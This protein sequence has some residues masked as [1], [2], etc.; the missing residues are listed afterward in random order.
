MKEDS[1]RVRGARQNNLK[2]IDIDIPLGKITVVTGVS[3]SGK[4][5]LAF[6]TVY[7]EGQRRYVETFSAYTRQFLDRMDRPRVDKIIGIPPAV[8]ID[9]ANP[10]RTSRSTVGTMTELADHLRI[11]FARGAELYCRSC[12]RRVRRDSPDSALGEIEAAGFRTI[13][14]TFAVPLSEKTSAESLTAILASQGFTRILRTDDD[15]LEVVQDRF[16]LSRETR[17]RLVED[18]ES[19]FR[20][21]KGRARVYHL[22]E[23]R[24]GVLSRMDFS[25]DFHCASCDIH[26]TEPHPGAFSFNSAVGAC[27]KCRG[28]GRVIDFDLDL[29]VPDGGKSLRDGAVK[30]WQ[31][32]SYREC[33]RDLEA[34]SRKRGVPLDIPWRDLE[35]RHRAWVVDGEGPWDDGVWYGIRRFFQWLE[36]K[37]YKMHIRVLLSKY[38]AYRVCPDCG[39]ARLKE[40]ALLWRVGGS[41]DEGGLTI[42]EMNLLPLGKLKDFFGSLRLPAEAA[43]TVATVLSGIRSRL[44]YLVDVGLDYLTLD[45]QTRTLSGG[46]VQRINLTTALGISLVNTLFVLDEPSIGLHSR[47]IGRLIGVLRDLRDSGNTL[48]VVEHDPEVILAA[49]HLID[50]GPGAGELGG[51]IVFT[52]SL[53]ELARNRDSVTARHLFGGNGRGPDIRNGGKVRPGFGAGS[54]QVLGAR[55]NNLKAPEIT[56]PLGGM[57]CVTG[58]SG[59]GKSTL[60]QEILY[61]AL[62]RIKGRA[63][64]TPGAHDGIRGHEFIDDII[65]VD[66][67]PLGRTARSNP[68]SYVG[69]TNG[70][71]KLFASHPEAAE[72][73]YGPGHFSFNSGA[74]RCPSCG[75]SGFEHVEMQFLSDVY[76]RCPECDGSRFRREILE[77]RIPGTAERFGAL[78]IAEVLELTVREAR[79]FF[80]GRK[81]ILRGLDCLA[82]VGLD[83]MRLGQAAPTLSAGEA[84]RLK[85]AGHLAESDRGGPRRLLFLLD[86]PTTGLHFQDIAVLLN[87][88]DTLIS[89]GYS[90]LVIEHNLDV[91]ARADHIVDLGPEGG[92]AGGRVVAEG[93]PREVA[94][95]GQGHTARA[96][97]AYFTRKGLPRAREARE[98][99]PDRLGTPPGIVIRGAREHNLK[100]ISLSIPRDSFTVITGVSGSGKSTIAF[101]IL[102]AEGQRRYL[103]SLNAYARQFVQPAARPDID[104]AFGLP[105]TVAIEQ[106][107]SRGGR[108]STVATVTEIYHFLRL[109]YV[110][111]GLRHCPDCRVPIQTDS[112]DSISSRILADSPDRELRILAPLVTG[113]KGF[114]G[115]VAKKAASRGYPFLRVDG[116]YLPTEPW[117]RLDRYREHTID[118]PVATIRVKPEAQED[119]RR[120][121]REALDMGKGT[122]KIDSGDGRDRSFSTRQACPSC[123]KGFPDLDP[124]LFSYNSRQG[125]CPSCFGT[126]LRLDGFDA[127]QSGEEIWWNSWYEGEEVPCPVCRGKRLRPEALAVTFR[128]LSI[129][130]ICAFSV[131]GL[132]S[133]FGELGFEGREAP[134]ARDITAEIVHRLH[135]LSR[136]GLSYITLDR[137]APT[138]SGGEARRIRLAAQLGSNLRGVLYILDEPTIGLHS[139]DNDMLL[140]TLKTLKDKG[141]TVVTVEHDEETIRRGDYII[142]LGPGGGVRGGEVVAA[143]SLAD[144]LGSGKS[145]TADCLLFPPRHPR[146]AARR[147]INRDTPFLVVQNP[148]LHNLRGDDV[149]FPLRRLTCVTGVS[150][151]GKSSLVR[152]ILLANIA[153][154]LR[155]TTRRGS[156]IGCS[157]IR[158]WNELNRVLEVDQT[159]IGKTPRS[160]PATYTGIWDDVRRLYADTP[161]ARVRG[162]TAGRF[163]FNV[164]GGR[165][166]ACDGQGVKKFEMSFLPDVTVPCETCG[167]ARFDEET[168]EITF[169]GKTIADVLRFNAE[170]AADFFSFHPRIHRALTLMVDVGLGYLS[171]GQ[172]SPTLSGGEAQRIKLVT[173]LSRARPGGKIRET[174][175]GGTL[176]ILDEPTVGLHM[177][178]VERLTR[179]LHRLVDSGGTV[180]VIEHNLDIVAEADWVIDLGPEGGAGGGKVV[181][182]GTPEEVARSSG[183]TGRY[184]D[185]FLRRRSREGRDSGRR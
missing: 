8:A 148:T 108:K 67:S 124:R 98:R 183:H 16:E 141:N 1:I 83:Y 154:L 144:I 112:P 132:E 156:F 101:D 58:V 51:D 159:P 182:F 123:G 75:G 45:R 9:A 86:E 59:S 63:G 71:R 168:R 56:L 27:P 19:A 135:F 118:L 100:N 47:D 65:L 66:Q 96:L 105:P 36:T 157:G 73:A 44:K 21:G 178:D 106:R 158:G 165:C 149:S 94:Q 85:L 6:D 3:G 143:G 81:D 82:A 14:V 120:W 91:I 69:A 177:A 38:R 146:R 174:P 137:A 34:F 46:E 152:E 150:G 166:P 80:H 26:Y 89:A 134:I 32:D 97:R 125:W 11:L 88:F 107:T 7:A 139:R 13:M 153:L 170:E 18:L 113:R 76:L 147:P 103:E 15:S 127:E 84:Q 20:F 78:S 160:C 31:T 138:L 60:V 48:L 23:D 129:A 155:R 92:E 10:V 33:Q 61:P 54:I 90:L 57:V 35:P 130:D 119:L 116:T 64:E 102:F 49:D 30:P 164:P 175:G 12:G 68:A 142:D 43:D 133:F 39:G 172:Q 40:E 104:G 114:H 25:T 169:K 79:E 180:V 5:S 181:A 28:F 151:S 121:V 72:R 179:V 171:L 24:T 162:Y 176:Y 128:G 185:E 2:N 50:L 4:S 122:V 163:S 173:E 29:A 161:E 136:V 74:G 140:D 77:V 93:T 70:I 126:G 111:L 41:R 22:A 62:R 184:L 99:K 109:L 95:K 110:K 37:S 87:A 167:G 52:G 131:A 53:E 145:R 55:E 17:S 42:H 117:P 115:D